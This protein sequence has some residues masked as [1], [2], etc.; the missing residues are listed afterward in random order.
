MSN[1][2]TADYV[3]MQLSEFIGEIVPFKIARIDPDHEQ[4]VLLHGVEAGG[5]WI[6]S[7]ELTN[8]FLTRMR[9]SSSPRT[10]VLFLPWHEIS[11][12]IGSIDKPGL[13]E[14]IID[15]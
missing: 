3:T 2:K 5:V 13:N 14:T 8:N 12:A 7:Q 11:F 1:I 4:E 9:V 6:E 10:I 15:E